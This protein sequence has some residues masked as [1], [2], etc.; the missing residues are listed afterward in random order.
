VKGPRS[1]STSRGVPGLTKS[2]PGSE[3]GVFFAHAGKPWQRQTNENSNGL[4]RQYFPKGSD[5][6]AY[7]L[8]DLR[9]V[10]ERL[11]SR[12][13]KHSVHATLIGTRGVAAT[14]LPRR[15]TSAAQHPRPPLP[16]YKHRVAL[17]LDAESAHDRPSISW[18]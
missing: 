1:G 4:L 14:R 17:D 18:R 16:A 15:A 3:R 11:N 7:S 5:L 2:L 8:Q 6:S 12:P 13:R 9:G 10:E